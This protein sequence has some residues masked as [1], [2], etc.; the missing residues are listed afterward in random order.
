MPASSC[1]ELSKEA[2][3][4]LLKMVWQVLDD[5][6]KGS[7]MQLP[8]EP[9]NQEL[10]EPA[11][12]FVT[13]HHNGELRGCIGSLEA[14]EPLWLNACKNAYASGYKDRRFQPLTLADRSGLS[15]EISVLSELVPM[16]NE[17]EA[18]LLRELRPDIDGLLLEEGSHRSVFLPSVWELLPTPEKFVQALKRKGGWLETYWS[19]DI[20]LHR[21]T[22]VVIEDS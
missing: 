6:M 3:S 15:L 21:F 4:Q 8:S 17:G 5:A 13:L 7:G 18:A 14:Q 20:S 1:F 11:A 22:T 19:E 12:C 10:L 16:N 2:R 9:S